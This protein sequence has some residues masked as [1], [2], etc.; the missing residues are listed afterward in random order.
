VKDP[1]VWTHHLDALAE[2]W[3]L[4]NGHKV[5][6]I[7]LDKSTASVDTVMKECFQRGITWDKVFPAPNKPKLGET[8]FWERKIEWIL[9]HDISENDVMFYCHSK[10]VRERTNNDAV[11]AWTDMMYSS[12][13]DYWP[14]VERVL[15][16]H[17]FAGSFKHH[18]AYRHAGN[19]RWHYSGTFFWVRLLELMSRKPKA[20]YEGYVGVEAYPGLKAKNKEGG[21]LFLDRLRNS[22]YDL[23]TIQEV[24]TP[25]WKK[26]VEEN[27]HNR[28]QVEYAGSS[29][30]DEEQ[31]SE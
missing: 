14:L 27:Q 16:D 22:L 1:G 21:V 19:H 12:N 29:I 9:S 18:T 5:I 2:R 4:F 23:K 31:T 8:L 25:Q 17:L 26:W 20:I 13:L 11:R 24:I 10:G 3:H 15:R 6:S 28:T 30:R 7:A